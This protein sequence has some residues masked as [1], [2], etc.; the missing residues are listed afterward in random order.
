[1]EVVTIEKN[2][3]TG[4]SGF[5]SAID[6]STDPIR[7]LHYCTYDETLVVRLALPDSITFFDLRISTWPDITSEEINHG[8]DVFSIHRNTTNIAEF[9]PS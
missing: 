7:K 6:C 2:Y 8:W 5:R 3:F 9:N 1:M 4:T